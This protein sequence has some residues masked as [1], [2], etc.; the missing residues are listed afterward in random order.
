MTNV[1]V[2][3]S[4]KDSAIARKLIDT[5]EGIKLDVWVDWEDIPPAVGWL[6]QILRGIEEADAFIFLVSPDSVISEVCNVEIGHAGKNNKRIIPIVVRDVD[7]KTVNPIIRDLNWIFAREQDS[8][9]EVI[10]KIKLAIELD[11][12]WLTEHR[13]LQVRALEWHRKKEPSLLLRGRDLRTA[14]QMFK[15]GL[16]KD[17]KPTDLQQVYIHFS[18][19]DERR[20]ILLWLGTAFA[21]VIMALLSITAYQ[22]SKIASLQAELAQKNELMAKDEAKN[23]RE[24]EGRAVENEQK[25][26]DAQSLAQKNENTA[27]A[28]RSAAKAQIYQSRTGELYTSTLLAIDSW[29]REP[30]SPEVEEIL[31]KNISLLPIPVANMSQSAQI[32]ALEFSP[33][34]N[35]FVTASA[36]KTVCEWN[37]QDGEKLFCATSS[38]SVNDVT[39]SPD[40]KVIVTGDQSGQVLILDA[41]IGK[42]QKKLDFDVEVWDVN[43]SPDSQSLAVT[44]DDGIITIIDLS[45]RKADYELSTVGRPLVSA[46]SPNGIWF[47]TGSSSGGITL[48]NLKTG[49]GAI[50]GPIHRGEVLALEF[51]PDSSVLVTGGADNRAFATLTRTGKLLFEINNQD[52][53]EDLA[54]GPDGSWFVTASDDRSIRV[55]DTES[56]EEDAL[57]LQD[58]FVKAVRVSPNGRWIATTGDDKTARVWNSATGAEILQIPL[59]SGGSTLAFSNE[60]KYLI[61]GTQNGEINIWNISIMT[62]PVNEIQFSGNTELVQFS[63][64]GNWLAASDENR[65]WLLDKEQYSSPTISPQKDPILELDSDVK[66]LVISPNSEWIGVSTEQGDLTIYN[67]KN[68]IKRIDSSSNTSQKLA[69]SPDSL[70]LITGGLNGKVLAWDVTTGKVVKT[71]FESNSSVMSLATSSE[72]LAIGLTDKVMILNMNSDEVIDEIES[73]GDHQLMAFNSQGS[74]LALSNSSGQ[75]SIWDQEN[76]EFTLDQTLSRGPVFSMTFNPQGEHLLIGEGNMVYLID[77]LTGKEITRIPHKIPANSLSFSPDGNLFASASLKVIQFWDVT[78]IPD[79]DTDHLVETACSRIVENFNQEAWTAFFGNEEYKPLCPNLP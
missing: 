79:V 46:F 21:V 41:K 27:K 44:R 40:G 75:I 74:F 38:G 37:V 73:P 63:P 28:Q 65:V 59:K 29:Q 8:F 50:T 31:R 61:S 58:G 5:F 33:V 72:L 25:A 68:R 55:W 1:I 22:Q 42:V 51:S 57:M 77:I 45:G 66:N 24:A 17:P 15:L 64:S 26:R 60:G 23:A 48:W 78:K 9:E 54:F 14:G 70:R 16:N 34:D 30:G 6:D 32:N 71:L 11:L 3:Y 52:R 53:V 69:F 76:G 2:S 7:P 20:R 62:A 19:R 13:R 43:I 56:G 12:E 49:G 10:N 39:F 4:R 18:T 67:V 35:T 36:D 47:A